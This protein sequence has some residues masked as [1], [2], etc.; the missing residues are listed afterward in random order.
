MSSVCSFE[1]SEEDSSEDLNVIHR[2]DQVSSSSLEIED[3]Q[4][5]IN[6]VKR[7][8]LETDVSSQ[9]RKDL[10][11]KLIRLRIKKEDLE[12]RKHFEILGE[13]ERLGHIII[14]CDYVNPARGVLFCEECGGTLWYLIT[15]VF[16]CK[17]CSYLLH[18]QCV[19]KVRRRCVGTF[20][21]SLDTEELPRFWD[22][23]LNLSI[24]PESSLAEQSFSC[25]E[26]E[27][28]FGGFSEARLCDYTG[29]YYCSR[30]HWRGLSSSPARI[31][32]NWDFSLQS[33]SQAALKYIGLISRK[34]LIHLE[35][36]N[37]S[38][39]AVIP[40]LATVLKLR[41]QL[42]SMKKYLMV[43]RLAGEERLLT[44]LHDRQHFV[45]SAE[46]FSFRDLI[47]INSGVLN[48]YLKTKLD[49]FKTHI[50]SC[51]LCMAKSFVCEICP[52][53]DKSCLFPF[54]DAADVC[55]DCEAVFHRE[56]FRSV[57]SCPRCDRKK[58]KR[59]SALAHSVK[60][61]TIDIE[62]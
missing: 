28:E 1:S 48:T 38:L 60:V 15:Q 58:E 30:C 5:A 53:K 45:D 10:V 34:P 52:G 42:L 4:E 51:V 43:C 61:Y 8:I 31:V 33:M 46:M 29:G 16:T 18:P 50:V 20:L 62:S 13:Q 24:C 47:D 2:F 56:C 32:R 9:S 27:A 21:T 17:V 22:G 19:A 40:E 6:G 11:H 14:P 59:E 39:T 49:T 3:V 36:L 7:T 25:L 44:L 54:D 37:P 23:S 55:C 57:A 41:H 35:K 12:N 26:C